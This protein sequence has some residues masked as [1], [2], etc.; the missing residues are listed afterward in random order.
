MNEPPQLLRPTRHSSGQSPTRQKHK[1]VSDDI[2]AHLAPHTAAEALASATGPLRTCLDGASAAERDFA[3]R[4]ALASRRVWEWVD[5]LG[6]WTWPSEG[7]AA[8]FEVPSGKRRKL[9][10]HVTAPDGE[11]DQYIGSVPAEEVARYE[12]RTE[13]IHRDM[14]KLD[15]EEIKS[16]VLT[17]HIIPLSRPSTPVSESNRSGMSS[18]STYTKMEDLTA[19]VTAIVVQMLPNLAR[20]SRLMQMWSMRLSVLQSMSPWLLAITDAEVALG[21]GWSAISLP[22]KKTQQAAEEGDTPQASTL[23][24]QDFNIMKVVLEKKVAKPGRS[25]DYMLDCLEGTPDTLPEQWLDR[26][27]AVEKDYGEWVVACERKI[28]ET[29]WAKSLRLRQKLSRP[30]SPWKE[31]RND[32]ASAKPNG[33]HVKADAAVT[34]PLPLPLLS[35]ELEE[36]SKQRR[37]G[38]VVSEHVDEQHT[39]PQQIEGDHWAQGH[40]GQAPT[41]LDGATDAVVPSHQIQPPTPTIVSHNGVQKAQRHG[42][43]MADDICSPHDVIDADVVEDDEDELELPPL[44]EER[45]RRDSDASQTSTLMHGASSHFGG[46]SSDPPEVSGSPEIPRNRIREAEYV[47]ASP[48]SSPPPAPIDHEESS[49]VVPSSPMAAL[50]EAT[51]PEEDDTSLYLNTPTE[52]SFVDDFDDSFSVSEVMGTGDRRDSVGD[53]QLRKQITQII[54]SIPAKIKLSAEPPAINLNPPDL[55]LPR[56]RKR[57]SKEP[58]RRSTSAMSTI[59]SRATSRATSRAPTPSFTLSPAK[60][61]RNRPQ[62]GQQEIKVYH[63]SRSTGEAPIKLFIRCV[64]ER[65][66]RVMVRVGGG[67]ADLSEY[68]KEYASHHGRRSAGTEKAKVEVRDLPR[69]MSGTRGPIVGSSPPSRPASAMDTTPTTPLNVRKTRKS[70]GAVGSEAPR[71]QPPKTPAPAGGRLTEDTPPSEGSTRSRSSSHLSWVEEDSSFLGL[72]G[73]SGKKVDMSEENKLWVESVKEKVRLVSGERKPPAPE[74]KN[75]FGEIGRVG[76]TKRLFRKSEVGKD[77]TV[78]K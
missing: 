40:D 6:D 54:E 39:Q 59:S 29:E 19:V 14:A 60:N 22:P 7:G 18:I 50:S 9:S 55:Q 32:E 5:E 15:V 72:A 38:R 26:L 23:T 58:V 70:V 75:R 78:K 76:G 27:E 65:G 11:A 51:I 35:T 33:L 34:L 10:I 71:L 45:E 21:S 13:E 49:L 41:G 31:T 73:P 61:P 62:R 42:W 12:R 2:L 47:N 57:P 63:L 68:L 1:R 53:Q 46:L 67:W 74:E 30:S 43:G 77:G 28:Q 8:G 20:L 4:A 3:V 24:R 64:G 52:A 56:L 48:P 16:H 66:E 37:D 25:L 69:V 17:N 44:W 36:P